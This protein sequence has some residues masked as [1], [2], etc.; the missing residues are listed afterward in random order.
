[1]REN[2]KYLIIGI[3][4]SSAFAEDVRVQINGAI[5]AQ[6]CNVKSSDLTK[7]V[8]FDDISPIIFNSLGATSESKEVT[9]GLENCTGNVSNLSYMFSGVPDDDNQNLLKVTGVN[10]NSP[11]SIA[12]GIAIEILDANKKSIPLN[13]MKKFNESI[14][15]STFNFKFNLRYKSTST[16]ISPGDASSS[17]YLDIYY[18]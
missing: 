13:T 15:T 5:L 7:N 3:F 11:D 12:T 9:I 4:C 10:N 16:D 2:Y 8:N 17:L 1:M 14:V 6:S 18:E